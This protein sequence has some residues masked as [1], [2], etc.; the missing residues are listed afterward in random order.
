[1]EAVTSVTP[2]ARVHLH[3]GAVAQEGVRMAKS[4]GN[5]TLAGDLLREHSPAAVR[6]LLFDRPWHTAWEFDHSSLDHAAERL[7][8]LYAAAGRTGTSSAAT[9][10]VTT[11]LLDDLD[12]PRAIEVAL[13]G[14]GEAA[15]LLLRVLTLA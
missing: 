14:G 12:V 11:A 3:V 7:Q 2:F 13:D 15:R 4:T 9:D 8:L 5:L 1:V 10:A 6:L